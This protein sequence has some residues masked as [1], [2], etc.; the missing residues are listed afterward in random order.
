MHFSKVYA[1]LLQDLPPELAEN[2]FQY[3]ELKK[4][5]NQIATELLALGLEPTVLHN[6]LQSEGKGK[7]KEK[8]TA[9]TVFYEL[10]TTSGKIEPRLRL[11]VEPPT[12]RV[13]EVGE[14]EIEGSSSLSSQVSLSSALQ[15][16]PEFLSG[17]RIG[18]QV[19]V[20]IPLTS[21]SAFFQLLATSLQTL[22]AHLVT[23]NAQ[24][25][26]T[27]VELTKTVSD[28]ARP[29][30]STSSGFRVLSGLKSDAGGVRVGAS[31]A[32]S[33]LNA[34]REIFALYVETEIF[35]SIHERDRGERSVEEAQNRLRKFAD[36]MTARGLKDGHLMKLKQSQDALDCFLQLN[37]FILN[38]KKFELANAEATRKILK[39]RMKRTALP[40]TDSN[41]LNS[42]SLIPV[43]DG[44]LPR[45]LVQE[46]GTTL[47]PIIPSLEDYQCFICMSL[48]FKPIRLACG[49]LFC[50]RCLVKMQKRGNG[51][52]PMCRSPCVLV[53]NRS[54]VDWAM[55]NFMRDWFPE[56]ATV[57]LKQN[58]REAAQEQLEELGL[59]EERCIM[60]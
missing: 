27:L 37:V 2:S 60:M 42:L 23:I 15:R 55:L 28:S 12:S 5:I 29:A 53:A 6:L 34:W 16:H 10:D 36:R 25:V 11:W 56:E 33:D 44:S 40:T 21:D 26:R 8:E 3:R 47:L 58:E 39:K 14:F 31:S 20:V 9:P 7:G 48:A 35:E 30:S 57:K 17:L 1:Q 52:C 54:N 32:K 41:N 24:F 22:Q 18:S 45:I 38:V 51:D 13:E 43:I 59:P 46:L 4:L 50:V 19:E 49:H